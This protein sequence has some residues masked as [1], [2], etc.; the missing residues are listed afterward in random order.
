MSSASMTIQTRIE[1][2]TRQVEA[3]QDELRTLRS[4]NRRS[5]Q[6]ARRR[7][8]QEQVAALGEEMQSAFDEL[9]TKGD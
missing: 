9:L 1:D 6:W 3:R 4:R 2:L 5:R 7:V 8:L